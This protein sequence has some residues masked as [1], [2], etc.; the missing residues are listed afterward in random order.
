M[1]NYAIKVTYNE[2][3]DH[4]IT[5]LC[6][7]PSLLFV[8]ASLAHCFDFMAPSFIVFF[9]FHQVCKRKRTVWC[10]TAPTPHASRQ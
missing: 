10:L 3:I 2:R 6:S 7:P 9:R 4:Q 5:C 8:L 1:T